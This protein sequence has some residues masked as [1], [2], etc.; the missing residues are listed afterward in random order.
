MTRCLVLAPTEERARQVAQDEAA[1]EIG[2]SWGRGAGLW[3][4]ERYTI[5]EEIPLDIPRLIERHLA[6]PERI[7]KGA[8]ERELLEFVSDFDLD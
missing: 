3:E 7:R 2:S 1:A 6:A 5:C 8:E 4:D